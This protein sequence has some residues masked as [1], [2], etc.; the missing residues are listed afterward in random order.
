MNLYISQ[1]V[2]NAPAKLVSILACLGGEQW[3]VIPWS[4]DMSSCR[5]WCEG[6]APVAAEAD[7]SQSAESIQIPR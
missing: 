6:I 1:R 5:W 2:G 3:L 4:A 7:F